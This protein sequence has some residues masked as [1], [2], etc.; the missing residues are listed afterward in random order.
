MVFGS[1]GAALA[2]YRPY[3]FT[4]GDILEMARHGEIVIKSQFKRG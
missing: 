3:G 1:I 4:L 2:H